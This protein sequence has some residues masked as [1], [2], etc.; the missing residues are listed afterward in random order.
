MTLE[1]EIKDRDAGARLGKIKVRGKNVETPLFLPVYNPNIPIITPSEMKEKY[2]FKAIMTN[3]YII[4]KNEVLREKALEKGIHALL[5]FDGVVFTDSGAY[6]SFK[7]RLE[8]RQEE[9]INFQ[10]SIDADVG[11]MLDVPSRGES[12]EEC[13]ESVIETAK[14]G[15]EWSILRSKDRNAWEGVIQGGAYPELLELSCRLMSNFDFDILAVG[16]PPKYWVNYNF[17]F[18]VVQGLNSRINISPEKPLHAFGMGNPIILP[19][20]TAI[21]YDLFDSASYAI[22]AKDGRYMTEWGVKRVEELDY[23]P[24]DCPLCLNTDAEELKTM[25]E[26]E[27]VNFLARHNLYM[28]RR[29]MNAIKQAIRENRLWELVQ[30]RARAHPRILEALIRAF[31]DGWNHFKTV[32]PIR[33]RSALFYSGEETILRP[34][35]RRA[36]ERVRERLGCDKI[37][38]ALSETYPFGQCLLKSGILN[39]DGKEYNDFEKIRI[40]ADYQFGSEVGLKLIPE[41]AFIEKSKRTGRIR[42][43][44]IENMLIGALRPSD[45][46]ISLS[47]E[48]A[49]RLKRILQPPK[50]RV[51]VAEDDELLQMVKSGGDVFSKFVAKCDL[52]IIPKEEVIVV[53]RN[54]SLLAVG[55]AVLAG[56]EM[57]KFRRG[58]AVKVRRGV[59]K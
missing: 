56:F 13:R 18:I 21:G 4:Y 24:C 43:I 57:G 42:R 36:L 27:R 9:I 17:E 20:L 22:Y 7:G 58:V 35:F 59:E 53:D 1:F 38:S 30:Q 23:L 41:D 46:F 51:Y 11:V 32:D 37:P 25:A 54:D 12:F 31:K 28:I 15:E 45:G 47:L 49:F 2:G 48:G 6:Q 26:D 55:Q 33:K 3:A 39:F 8:L 29:E 16:V 44:W 14:R 52:D 40:I 10:E 50:Y 34:E 19:L 5:N